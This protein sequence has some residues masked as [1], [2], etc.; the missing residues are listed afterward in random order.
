M[1]ALIYGD[2]NFN[3]PGPKGQTR[4]LQLWRIELIVL[5][6]V[7]ASCLLAPPCECSEVFCV[8][9]GHETACSL[10][11]RG[12]EEAKRRIA[13]E[14]VAG[15]DHCDGLPGHSLLIYG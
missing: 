5:R 3:L 11:P 2:C 10:V 9:A 7:R 13:S 14:I 1:R 12:Q 4:R 6:V 15:A 8:A